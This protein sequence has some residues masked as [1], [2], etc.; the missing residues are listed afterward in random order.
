[1]VV[2]AD[3]NEMVSRLSARLGV[4]PNTRSPIRLSPMSRKNMAKVLAEFGLNQGAEIGVARG[5]H[6][7]I[8]C[9]ANPSLKL[10]CVDAYLEY[11]GY[12][13]YSDVDNTFKQAQKRLS[14]YACSFI[15]KM[16]MEALRYFRDGALDFVYIDAA[17]D[18]R[19]VADDI[20]EWSKKVRSGGIVFGHDYK[21]SH[22]RSRHK[23]EVKDVVDAFCYSRAI[24]PWFIL[25]N[26]IDRDNPGWLF[27]K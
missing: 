14:K 10:Y 12:V 9:R 3:V 18:F 4:D 16:S 26:D 15:R 23:L 8:L 25:A 19:S 22:R 2:G 21:R 1:M 17:H 6:A 13:G 11:P 27:V 20:C 24:R 7:E 5:D